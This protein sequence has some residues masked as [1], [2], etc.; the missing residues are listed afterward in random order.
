MNLIENF[1]WAPREITNNAFEKRQS[2]DSIDCL[3]NF[4]TEKNLILHQL[5]LKFHTAQFFENETIFRENK[6]S[7]FE[8]K[9]NLTFM[10]KSA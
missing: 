4:I 1:R 2:S 5:P 3:P 10:G 9:I 6:E 8:I 7:K